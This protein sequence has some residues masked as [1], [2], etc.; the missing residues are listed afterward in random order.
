MARKG[1]LSVILT[2]E[3]QIK[4][5]TA[6]GWWGKDT[7]GDLFARHVAERPDAPALIDPPNRADLAAG[8]PLRLT[9]AELDE[10]VDRLAAALVGMGVGKDD[11]VMVQL[12]NVAELIV[13]YLAAARIGAIVSPLAVQYRTHELR[14]MAAL[15]E[16]K[17]FITVNRFEDY[18]YARMARELQAEFPFIETILAV[19]DDL[20]EG[21]GSLR[22][23]LDTP[24][25]ADA[26]SAYLAGTRWTAN[27][28][29]TICWT[30][31]T[32]A[33][34]KGVPRSHNLWIAIARFTT[35]GAGFE[36]G[37][38]LLNP[39]PMVNMSGIGGMLVPW[40][41]V[42]GVL[43]MHHP[44]NLPV[45]LQ[46]IGMERIQYTVAPPVLLNLL[47]LRP[48][49]L[50]QADLS[51][52]ECIGSGSAPL[53]AWMVGEWKERHGIDVLNFF[54]ANEGTSLVGAPG[55]IPDPAERAEVF[56]RFGAAG[57][58]WSIPLANAIQT[59]LVDPRTGET[60]TGPGQAGELAIKGPTVFDGY[61]QRA[62]LTEKAFDDEGYFRTG[63]LFELAGEGDPP[64]RYRF[65]GR[66][67]DV[68]IRA[69]MM[70]SPEELE[71][72]VSGHPKVGEVAFVGYVDGRI[73]QEEQ[74]AAAVVPR[75]EQAITLSDITA[76]LREKDIA[77]YK[78]PKKLLVLDAL[79]RNPVGKVLKRDIREQLNREHGA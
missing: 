16:P 19:G 38:R 47:L 77:S 9:Y 61:W 51:S 45:F 56:P 69:G 30:S 36:P 8:E 10:R 55:D 32:E 12:P 15:A 29:Y 50:E 3:E 76:Y 71:A 63:D 28:V 22:A 5:Y 78:M 7:I 43:V 18:D 6:R 59:R 14:Q 60:I 25:D 49:L 53:S 39:F 40:L 79:P 42:G 44:L 73:L 13:V 65:V 31:G 27:D 54:G 1:R 17:I 57:F 68:I 64:D 2:P 70:I 58:D 62:H 20:P 66:L 41:L 67:K 52:I 74:V 24:H 34:P 33:E 26:L 35:D 37:Y 72:L 23:I 21:V 48:A 75:P 46:Q 11:V 4:E